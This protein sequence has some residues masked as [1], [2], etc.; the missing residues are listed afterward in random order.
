MIVYVYMIISVPIQSSFPLFSNNITI[1]TNLV[2]SFVYISVPNVYPV[3]LF[4]HI[5]VV[6]RLERLG[7]SQYFQQEI[8][9]CLS[10]VHR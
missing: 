9:D 7:I 1:F 3:D 10:Y 2:V 4:E 8:K 5:W 6:D